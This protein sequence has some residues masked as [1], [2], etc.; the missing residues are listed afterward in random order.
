MEEINLEDKRVCVNCNSDK[1]YTDRKGRKHWYNHDGWYCNNCNNKLFKNPKWKPT[2]VKRRINFKGRFKYI[3]KILRIGQCSRCHRKIG[4]GIK[5]TSLHHTK[6]DE[7]DP[8]A[9]TVELCNSCH[10]YLHWH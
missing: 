6:Y 9:H 1:T 8:R 3:K 5:R 10:R 4:E 7:S 2:T